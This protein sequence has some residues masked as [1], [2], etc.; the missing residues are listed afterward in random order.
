[1]HTCTPKYCGVRSSDTTP[2]PRT[3]RNPTADTRASRKASRCQKRSVLPP[4]WRRQSIE[5]TKE[6]GASLLIGRGS[7]VFVVTTSKPGSRA[8]WSPGATK[9]PPCRKVD[10]SKICRGSKP[11]RWRGNSA[12]PLKASSLLVPLTLIR[13]WRELLDPE[14]NE[15]V[16]HDD[17]ENINFLDFLE[18]VPGCAEADENDVEKWL[19]NNIELDLMFNIKNMAAV[20]D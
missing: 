1:M 12:T 11:S 3:M 2:K 16:E 9:D 18:R 19:Q 4:R 7:R 15:L 6:N 13:L 14:E 10:A 8:F 17:A 20:S 5:T